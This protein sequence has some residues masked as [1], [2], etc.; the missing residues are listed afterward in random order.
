MAQYARDSFEIHFFI[1]YFCFVF[2]FSQRGYYLSF[3]T[4]CCIYVA[5]ERCINFSPYF[6]ICKIQKNKNK[7]ELSFHI[8]FTSSNSRYMIVLIIQHRC[9]CWSIGSVV[10]PQSTL[11]TIK[12]W[13]LSEHASG[14][15][16]VIVCVLQNL[17]WMLEWWWHCL[18]RH[19]R[20]YSIKNNCLISAN[21][22]TKSHIF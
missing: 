19:N 12:K 2:V 7:S 22:L 11:Q 14:E 9:S 1:L 17:W 8:S 21:L 16:C 4:I 5:S 15:G 3:C 10:T 6:D 20:K 13:F 18:D